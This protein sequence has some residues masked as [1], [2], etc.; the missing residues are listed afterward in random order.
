MAS[1]LCDAIALIGDTDKTTALFQ[2]MDLAHRR[3]QAEAAAALVRLGIEAGS[4]RLGGLAE[5]PSVR[6]RVLAYAEELGILSEIHSD[7][8]SVVYG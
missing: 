1:A 8:S 6:L 5:E 4:Q 3:I 2:A 7:R